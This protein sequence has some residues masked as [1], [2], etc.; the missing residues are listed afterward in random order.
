MLPGRRSLQVFELHQFRL[1]KFSLP[2][3]GHFQAPSS[4]ILSSV[5]L[6]VRDGGVGRRSVSIGMSIFV[7]VALVDVAV[8]C[9]SDFLSTAA[10]LSAVARNGD[11]FNVFFDAKR[12][13]LRAE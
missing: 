3:L 1:A 6:S 13:F 12:S 4:F 8:G 9:E 2:Q 5:S 7:V 11:P 10:S